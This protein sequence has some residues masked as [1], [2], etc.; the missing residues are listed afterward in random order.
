M[1]NGLEVN[2]QQFDNMDLGDLS[3]ACLTN[4]TSCGSGG[5]LS[6][7]IKT[8]NTF[9]YVPIIGTTPRTDA[10]FEIGLRDGGPQ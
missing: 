3:T 4:P 6:L 2:F 7:W 1:C 8:Q 10:G 9:G 5:S